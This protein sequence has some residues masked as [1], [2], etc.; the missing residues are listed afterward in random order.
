[1][2]RASSAPASGHNRLDF[3]KRARAQAPPAGKVPRSRSRFRAVRVGKQPA[4]ER[5]ERR[6]RRPR[7]PA[8]LSNG[9]RS[10]ISAA[11]PL[12]ESE[13]TLPERRS[14]LFYFFISSSTASVI[15]ATASLIVGSDTGA[16]LLECKL[17]NGWPV[18]L[19]S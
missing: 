11:N 8:V 14:R 19:L 18:L 13:Q 5:T 3:A 16:N 7:Q 10:G 2:R 4:W 6:N 9:R 12:V 1:M 17:G 15:A